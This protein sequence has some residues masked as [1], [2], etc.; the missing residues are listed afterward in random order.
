MHSIILVDAI[1]Q[2][3]APESLQRTITQMLTKTVGDSILLFT[4]MHVSGGV[5][6][7][8]HSIVLNYHLF[9]LFKLSLT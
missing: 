5:G 2:L 9:P 4:L 3:N 8:A 6:E 1:T 7:E